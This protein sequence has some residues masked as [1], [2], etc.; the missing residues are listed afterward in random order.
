MSAIPELH[1]GFIITPHDIALAL[2]LLLEARAKALAKALLIEALV[3]AL[4][5]PLAEALAKKARVYLP[6]LH[7]CLIIGG[8][9][10]RPRELRQQR[11]LPNRGETHEPHP[12]V[13]GLAHVE[14]PS[15]TSAP[16]PA[17]RISLEKLP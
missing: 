5:E 4:A 1:P 9:A 12:R 6:A 16:S 8:L 17:A 13:A 2:H 14:T 10:V 7:T 3:K 11:R 15:S